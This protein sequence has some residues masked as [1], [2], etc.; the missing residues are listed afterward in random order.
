[1][2]A[3]PGG[4]GDS[5]GQHYLGFKNRTIQRWKSNGASRKEAEPL[6]QWD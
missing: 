3:L 5:S 4:G 2:E 6:S 1:M